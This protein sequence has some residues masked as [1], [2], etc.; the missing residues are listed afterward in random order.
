MGTKLANEL[1]LFDMAGN[2]TES[3][4][5]GF[6][7]DYNSPRDIEKAMHRGGGY[8]IMA[9]FCLVG[10]RSGYYTPDTYGGVGLRIAI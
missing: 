9:D 1:G 8:G 4:A 6:S 7:M 5:D 10:E 2:V 3:L